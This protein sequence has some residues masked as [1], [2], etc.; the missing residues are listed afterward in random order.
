MEGNSKKEKKSFDRVYIILLVFCFLFTALSIFFTYYIV[1]LQFLWDRPVNSIEQFI[2]N[3]DET[4][5]P[6]DRGDIM[7]CNGRI[8]ASSTPLYDIR[9]DC[10]IQQ[11]YLTDGRKIKIPKNPTTKKDSINEKEW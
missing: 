10:C 1:H 7:D 11:E 9:M 5:I 3:Y 6:P 2:P 4:I 8:L